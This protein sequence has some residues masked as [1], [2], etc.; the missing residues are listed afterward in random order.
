METYEMV[1]NKEKKIISLVVFFISICMIGLFIY[2][3]TDVQR[4][5]P[6]IKFPLY[7]LSTRDWT[8]DNVTITVT[9]PNEKISEYS[10]DGG[11]NF[12]KENS[13][14]AVDNGNYSI[15]VKDING[16]VSKP[17][18]FRISNIDREAPIINFETS[19]T[20]Q[21]NQ[22]FNLKNGVIATDGDGSGLNNN[23]VVTPD[24]I[25]TSVPGTYTVTYTAFDRVGNYTEKTRTIVVTDHVGVTYYRYRTATIKN[26][27]CEPYTCN[28]VVTKSAVDS[29]VCPT[30]YSFSEPNECCQTCYKTCKET[31]WG[32][33]SEWTDQKVVP[34]TTVEVE[35][36]VE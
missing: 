5:K 27:Q 1:D 2:L 14:S 8:S 28:C 35:T 4:H 26:Y 31:I 21:L 6:L 34:S 18:S 16:R 22:V 17:V 23:Y 29:K 13:Y 19:T 30:G 9:S 10:F 24:K 3:Y 33:W 32:D 12:Q 25:D 20:V 36:K 7:T 15:V 11:K